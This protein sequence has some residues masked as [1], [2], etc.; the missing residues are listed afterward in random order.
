MQESC[1]HDDGCWP[2]GAVSLSDDDLEKLKSEPLTPLEREI[3]AGSGVPD[4]VAMASPEPAI[5][6]PAMRRT[7]RRYVPRPC[8]ACSMHPEGHTPT[9]RNQ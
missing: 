7:L 5:S 8:P 6:D 4:L 1:P 9:C 3:L 2:A